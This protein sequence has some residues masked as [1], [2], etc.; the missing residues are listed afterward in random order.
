MGEASSEREEHMLHP[1]GSQGSWCVSGVCTLKGPTSLAPDPQQGH[2]PK[3]TGSY[4]CWTLG[5]HSRLFCTNFSLGE[6]QGACL[7]WE[8]EEKLRDRSGGQRAGMPVPEMGSLSRVKIWA[9]SFISS[10]KRGTKSTYSPRRR[11]FLI[12]IFFLLLF[13]TPSRVY[14]F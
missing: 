2:A 6:K 8:L 14:I 4:F 1:W 13:N 11:A 5:S 12:C 7:L 10:V 9:D 3:E